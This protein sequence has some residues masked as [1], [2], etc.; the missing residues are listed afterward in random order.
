MTSKVNI[1][2]AGLSG[3]L[4]ANMLRHRAVIYERQKE[5]PNNHSALL[6]FRSGVFGT[7]LGI[8]FRE[9]MMVKGIYG[10]NSNPIKNMIQYSLKVTGEARTD[11][12]LLT[13]FIQEKRYIAP[14]DLIKTMSQGVDIRYDFL[15]AGMVDAPTISTI[16]MPALMEILDYPHR[17][18]VEFK[19]KGGVNLTAVIENC[20]AYAT[21]YYPDHN[22]GAYRASI[23][24]DQLIIEFMDGSVQYD[25]GI[26]DGS[27]EK[28][29]AIYYAR[30]F[31]IDPNTV[32]AAQV[33]SQAY[34]KILPI[35][36]ELRRDFLHWATDKHNVYSLGRYATWRPGL[37]LDDLVKDVTLISQ[38]INKG[39]KYG[40]ARHR[41]QGSL[42]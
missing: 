29:F 13:G 2:G 40:A 9:V 6:R 16:P 33:K 12:S 37:L 14:R 8:P 27:S 3:L 34:A 4:A 28:H 24:G 38:W 26:I 15:L 41:A 11:R 42:I 35:D 7:A 39:G 17:K 19:Y 5:L 25:K 22:S 32:H 18:E 10:D 21:F 1:I 36:D 30:H 20:D 23:T 31:G